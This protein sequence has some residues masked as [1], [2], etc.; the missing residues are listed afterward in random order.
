MQ[1][2]TSHAIMVES[3]LKTLAFAESPERYQVSGDFDVSRFHFTKAT[4]AR[5]AAECREFLQGLER[6]GH[7]F[8]AIAPDAMGALL[9]YGRNGH[10]YDTGLV[11]ASDATGALDGLLD[12]LGN[13]YMFFRMRRGKI[14]M[15]YEFSL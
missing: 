15:A 3:Y 5:A 7:C 4:R 12:K 11:T 8:D 9:A 2:A 13:A 10:E 14:E 1:A 6:T